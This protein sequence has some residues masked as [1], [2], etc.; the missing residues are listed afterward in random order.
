MTV[1][2]RDSSDILGDAVSDTH[3]SV[4]SARFAVPVRAMHRDHF[5]GADGCSKG[6]Q[7][8]GRSMP[9]V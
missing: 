7:I 5:P 1:W 2:I 3:E 8:G 4:K 6:T 9:A